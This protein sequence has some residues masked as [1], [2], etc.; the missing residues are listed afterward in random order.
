MD[1]PLKLFALQGAHQLGQLIAKHLHVSLSQLEQTTF[2]DGE[3]LLRPLET[4]RNHHVYV[5]QSTHNPA[6]SHLMELLMFVDALRRSSAK[7][8]NVVMPYYGYSRQDRVAKSREPITSRL[9]ADLLVTSGVDHI[10]TV[11]I[12][13]LQTQG[14]F[15]IPFDNISPYRLFAQAIQAE[16][17]NCVDHCVVVSPDH[18]SVVR[19]RNFAEVLGDLPIGIVDK[20]RSRPNVAESVHFIGDVNGKIAIII[21]DMIDTGRT[22]IG[23]ASLLK[24]A[25][26]QQVFALATHAVLSGDA[27]ARLQASVIE[28]IFITD[29]IPHTLPTKFK[30]LSLAPLL[31]RVI[32]HTNVGK[33]LSP[34][35]DE[36]TGISDS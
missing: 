13:T 14:F 8:I 10:I 36:F 3:V 21:D 35:F 25:G 23:A 32:H 33:P 28:K 30:T 6:S 34:I 27:I 24:Q 22:L 11:D 29:T 7:T 1:F 26:A 15:K 16:V 9:I 20:R 18:G 5:V 2:S 12:H 19:A 17:E 4:V 31:A